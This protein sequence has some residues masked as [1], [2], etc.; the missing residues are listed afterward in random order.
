MNSKQKKTLNEI[1]YDPIKSSILWS[2]IE[3]LFKALGGY[4]EEG[5]GSRVCILLN[6]VAAVFHRP[7]P[8]KETDKGALKSVRNFLN[9]AGVNNNE[10]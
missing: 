10:V 8:Q 1:F 9:N 3:S 4:I 2:D 6:G 5:S 7:H